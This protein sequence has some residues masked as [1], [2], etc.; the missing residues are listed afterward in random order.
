MGGVGIPERSAQDFLSVCPQ[1][2]ATYVRLDMS[3]R[4]GN[5]LSERTSKV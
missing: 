3:S 4:C 2:G 1:Y 5:A